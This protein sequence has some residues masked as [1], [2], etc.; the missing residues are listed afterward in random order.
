VARA[1]L[2]TRARHAGSPADA[3]TEEHPQAE[4]E[5]RVGM[6]LIVFT[7]L[8][9]FVVQSQF[10][11][12]STHI[13]GDIE[14][15]RGVAGT[16]LG[17]HLQ[18]QGPLPG[19]LS[20]YGG[21]YPLVLG[22]GSNLLG[23]SFEGL[24]SVVSWFATLAWPAVL[25]LLARRIWPGRLL[26]QGALVFIGTVGSSLA[27]RS[28]LAWV[29]S[30]LPSGANIWPL[31]PRDVALILLVLALGVVMRDTRP[32]RYALAGAV[33]GLGICVQLQVGVLT[34]GAIV[35]WALTSDGWPLCAT[36]FRRAALAGTA[37]ALVS[38][39]WWVPRVVAT[40]E[41]RP[42]WLQGEPG[43]APELSL[44]GVVIGLGATGFLAAAGLV[45]SARRRDRTRPES[46]FLWWALACVPLIV[47][48]TLVGDVG[49]LIP[50]RTWFLASLPLVVLAARAATAFLRIG[51]LWAMALLLV[52][53]IAV[54]STVEVAHAMKTVDAR[55][56]DRAPRE[57]PFADSTWVRVTDRLA[58]QVRSEGQVRLLAP[59]NDALYLWSATGAQP[60]SL[61][62]PGYVKLGFDPAKATG[63]GY[64]ERVHTTQ[65]AFAHGRRALCRLA[66]SEHLDVAV[67]RAARGRVAFY[68]LRP[69]A[70]W[71]VSPP[72]R[73]EA[74]RRREVAPGVIYRDL[75]RSE[76]LVLAPTATLP[77][78]FSGP[79]IREVE[80][81]VGIQHTTDTLPTLVLRRP[82]GQVIVPRTTRDGLTASHRFDFPGGLPPGIVISAQ[83][84]SEV[85][86]VLGYESAADLGPKIPRGPT[87][88]PVALTTAELCAAPGP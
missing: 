73:T 69:S 31:Y 14:F 3:K 37:A 60:F 16:M 48:G 20:Y 43:F 71:R 42:L 24:L 54:P 45:L 36:A 52:L 5:R 72:A 84:A 86:R 51:P 39:W 83:Q 12:F 6:A 7:F 8:F 56:V 23:T 78:G 44:T 70:R 9:A 68:D 22:Y 64:L 41:Y 35:A 19:L 79:N 80:V 34:A 46:F 53:V 15:H 29:D 11:A 1:P 85:T 88:T 57:E 49:V 40:L 87:A 25:L 4:T 47:V 28:N 82:D 32:W 81:Q 27:L 13:H 18:G 66:R 17:G 61:W 38:A 65:Q 59:D 2:R 74:T 75:N 10:F 30:L 21:L 77:L 55:W 33:A 58:G 67:L 76:A 63:I 50:S 26:E 62:T